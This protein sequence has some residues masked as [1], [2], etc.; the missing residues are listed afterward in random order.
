MSAPSKI[1][2]QAIKDVTIVN[3]IDKHVRDLSEIE[4]IGQELYDLVDNR[5]C[6]KI[7]LD[8]SKVQ[9]LSS[10]ALSVMLKLQEKAQ[11]AKSRIVL[12]GVNAE[13]TK[14]FKITRLEKLFKFYKTEDDAL[15]SFGI[16]SAG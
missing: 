14:L 6:R 16:T 2:I 8:F 3:F 5:G 11:G 4:K 15:I 1:M 12:C 13:L 9:G 10:Q 7:I